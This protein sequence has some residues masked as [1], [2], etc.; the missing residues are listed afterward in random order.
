MQLHGNVRSN[1]KDALLSFSNSFKSKH[2][3]MNKNLR[4]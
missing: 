2:A 1:V 3:G 4:F